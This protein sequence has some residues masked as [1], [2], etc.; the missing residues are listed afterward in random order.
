[1]HNGM[2]LGIALLVLTVRLWKKLFIVKE[3]FRSDVLAYLTVLNLSIVV[4]STVAF[5][6]IY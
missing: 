4:L 5:Y 6:Y 1:M 2:K 3:L